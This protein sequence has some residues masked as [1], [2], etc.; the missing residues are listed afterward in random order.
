MLKKKLLSLALGTCLMASIAT[1]NIRKETKEVKAATGFTQNDFLKVNGT[2]VKNNY[3]K[4]NNVYLRGT[5]IG[6]LFV[7]ESWMSSTDARDQK[8]IL[9]NLTNRFGQTRALELLDYYESNYFTEADFDRCKNLGMSVLRIPFTYLNLYKKSGNNWVFRDDAFNR[10]DW[11]V[12]QASQRGMYVILD[13]H[14]AFGS[15]NGQDHSGE[16]IDNVNKFFNSVW[17]IICAQ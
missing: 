10:M 17:H 2:Y 7:Q 1:G 3:G 8:T 15:Q 11:I 5:N 6:N 4:G 12:N 13:L 14:G 9:E 16:V